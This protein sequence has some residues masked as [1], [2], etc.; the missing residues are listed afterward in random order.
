MLT[1]NTIKFL[2]SLQQKKF[3][4]EYGLFV[5]EGAKLV[6]DLVQSHFEIDTIY[7]TSEW[8]IESTSKKLNYELISNKE[9]LRISGLATP[10]PVLA[11]LKTPN[12]GLSIKSIDKTLSIALDDI[13][14]PGNL[15]TI[16]RL[17]DWFG[18]ESIICSMDTVDAFSPKVVQASMGAISRVKVVYVDLSSFLA[19]AKKAGIP[20]YGTFLNGED[21]YNTDLSKSGIVVMGNEG[22]GISREIEILI[23][24]RVTIPSFAFTGAGSESLNVAMSTAIICSEFKRRFRT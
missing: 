22:N 20:I 8:V 15:G 3:R 24:Q 10:S 4:K 23:T 19:N 11:T 12:E 18:I 7:H 1:A 5:A 13:Q 14:D 2:K 17:S 9:M 6:S 16:I 21:I